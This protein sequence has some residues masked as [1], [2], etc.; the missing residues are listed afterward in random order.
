MKLIER[1]GAPDQKQIGSVNDLYVDL[2]T[3]DVYR[4][5][6][7][8]TVGE[9]LGGSSVYAS[10]WGNTEYTWELVGGSGGGSIFDDVDLSNAKVIDIGDAYDE[11]RVHRIILG[12]FT[13]YDRYMVGYPMGECRITL[14]YGVKTLKTECFTNN[15]WLVKVDLPDTVEHIEDH[16]F[17]GDYLLELDSLPK[18]LVTIDTAAFD[19]CRKA[20]FTEIPEGVKTIGYW[21][22]NNCTGLTTLTFKGTPDSI[23]AA[24][25]EGC[26]ILT[27]INVPWAEGAVA[28]APWAATNATINYNYRG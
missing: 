2:D 23:D 5:T 20:S 15:D 19:G 16:A 10:T 8:K 25:F 26:T 24:A 1:Y 21:A 18:S 28:G 17:S 6:G 4:C 13:E 14:P 7:I 9:E 12:D 22:F 27:T 11:Y 3:N